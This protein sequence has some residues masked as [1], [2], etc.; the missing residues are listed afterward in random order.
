MTER[1]LQ[2]GDRVEWRTGKRTVYGTVERVGTGKAEGLA[3]VLRDTA[4][5]SELRQVK[6][7]TRSTKTRTAWPARGGDVA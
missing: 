5:K 1:A 4:A 6:H 2:P 3:M 7:L